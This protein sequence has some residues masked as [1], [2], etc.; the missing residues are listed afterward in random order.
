MPARVYYCDASQYEKL[1][2]LLEYDP[3]LDNKLTAEDLEKIKNDEMANV[4]FAR[5]DYVIKDGAALDLDR[6][7]YYLY[8][9]ANE[10]FLEK[11]E[12]KLKA[13]IEGISR[14]GAEEERKIIDSI[15]EERKKGEEGFGLIFG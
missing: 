6:E 14:A 7:K 2:R 9:N 11:A 1:K 12:K 10:E 15:A 3:Y 5:Q 4:I 8:L 13:E